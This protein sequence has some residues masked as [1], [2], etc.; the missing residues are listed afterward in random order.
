MTGTAD[1]HA[2]CA[3]AHTES[4]S[5]GQLIR[6]VVKCLLNNQFLKT[7]HTDDRLQMVL[8]AGQGLNFSGELSDLA[9]LTIVELPMA[10]KESVRNA[11]GILEMF[12]YRD[13]VLIVAKRDTTILRSFIANYRKLSQP[14]V[15]ELE[16]WSTSSVNFLDV[17]VSIVR[18]ANSSH[19]T[20]RPYIKPTSGK[21]PLA[22]DSVH[23]PSI[24]TCWPTA[25]LKRISRLCSDQHTFEVERKRF[26]AS[27]TECYENTSL[28][29]LLKK[30][31]PRVSR[32]RLE[33]RAWLVVPYSPIFEKT[34][35][36]AL[37]KTRNSAGKQ[38]ATF[39][40]T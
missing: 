20:F 33:K 14:Y 5:Q 16:K 6:E 7:D 3:A 9:L 10:L 39:F 13:D 30:F 36:R 23:V 40:W 27:F 24:H 35:L 31:E 4:T 22:S 26:V 21:I 19:L 15:V 28:A 29:A 32:P 17:S 11:F 12:R 25:E 34:L 8:G 37:S 1:F 2:R 18:G 38:G